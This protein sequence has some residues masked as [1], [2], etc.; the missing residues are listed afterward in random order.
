MSDKPVA[1][2]VRHGST[3]ATGKV[4]VS[5]ADF[6][7]DEQGKR[8]LHEAINFLKDYDIARIYSSPSSVPPRGG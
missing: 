8:E 7:L 6:P 1:L 4:F 5:R 2:L 3:T